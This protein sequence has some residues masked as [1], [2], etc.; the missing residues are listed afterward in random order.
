MNN[1]RNLLPGTVLALATLISCR[2]VGPTPTTEAPDRT[3][4]QEELEVIEAHQGDGP[5]SGVDADGAPVAIRELETPDP[6]LGDELPCTI[7]VAVGAAPWEYRDDVT[8]G[9]DGKLRFIITGDIGDANK[10]LNGTLKGVENVCKEL[11][12][13]L[14]LLPGDLIYGTGA[15]SQLVWDAVWHRGFGVLNVPFAAVLG[16]H[17][18][19]VDPLPGLKREVMYDSDGKSGLIM[20]GPSYA[21]RIL[22]RDGEPVMAVAGLDTDSVASPG[23]GMPGLGADSLD[24]AC[25]EDVPVVWMGHHPI[26]SQ[27]F[28]RFHEAPLQKQLRERTRDAKVNGCPISV[29]VAG[30]DHDLQAYGP[31]C[32]LLGTPGQV[33]SGAS[34]GTRSRF[35]KHLETCPADPDAITTYHTNFGGRRSGFAWMTV[36]MST[37]DVGVRFYAAD[38]NGNVE[39]LEETGWEGGFKQSEQ[40]EPVRE[41]E[42]EEV[43]ELP[44]GTGPQANDSTDT[45]PTA[46]TQERVGNKDESAWDTAGTR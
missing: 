18:Y 34:Q 29:V 35:S 38:K 13:D 32:E 3:P 40:D 27:G 21:L 20:P 28:H 7:E 33:L 9:Q 19:R 6:L 1:R 17:G 10:R 24:T 36:D 26:S 41:L 12:C 5:E 23:S 14:G 22:G 16:N 30:H 44:E 37:G 25:N 31:S 8:C 11:G 4:S 45:V 15:R 42:V 2:T 43:E 39:L 46:D